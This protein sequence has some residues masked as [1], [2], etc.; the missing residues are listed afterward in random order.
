MRLDSSEFFLIFDRF[1]VKV[2]NNCGEKE[3]MGSPPN[4]GKIFL[5]NFNKLRKINRQSAALCR[6]FMLLCCFPRFVGNSLLLN[7]T[8]PTFASLILAHDTSSWY[9]RRLPWIHHET[10][11]CYVSTPVIKP[12]P[13]DKVPVHRPHV[14]FLYRTEE[15]INATT[16]IISPDGPRG[17]QESGWSSR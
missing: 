11:Y 4:E 15:Q 14:D 5:R 12:H 6:T 8:T 7:V 17:P 10:R 9:N 3:Q 13:N 2:L 16:W 1:W